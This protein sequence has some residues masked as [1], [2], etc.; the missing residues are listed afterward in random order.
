MTMLWVPLAIVGALVFTT[1][2][3]I[4]TFGPKNAGY[5]DHSKKED[6]DS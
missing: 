6:I 4:H 1:L 2:V 5:P 3:L